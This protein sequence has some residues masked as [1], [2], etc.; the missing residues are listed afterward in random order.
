M[1]TREPDELP[2]PMAPKQQQ[3]IDR[4][5]TLIQGTDAV[6]ATHR[7]NPPNVIGYP[8]L[9]YAAFEKWRSSSCSL[10]HRICGK[11]H[12]H[13]VAFEKKTKRAFQ[14]SVKS[15]RGILESF[16]DDFRAGDFDSPTRD[17]PEAIDSI[18]MIAER[19][20][21]VARQLRARHDNRPTLELND[22][23]DMQDLIHALLRLFFD[24]VRVEEWT[25][26]YAGGSSRVD[27]LLKPEQIVIE[28]KR[29]RPTLRA[30]E[31]GTQ[32]IDDIARYRTHP[33]CHRL[34]CFV[35]DPEGLIPNPR[36]LE[37]DLADTPSDMPVTVLIRPS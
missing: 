20:H 15:G 37:T 31:L 14:S 13:T 10:L 8:T 12:P 11:E 9:D 24:D 22:E 28:T 7:P 35:Y 18:Q 21:S 30:K 1:S 26:S 25:P 6:I 19:F 34:V 29:A 5:E 23:Y 32:L 4:L 2:N 33:D 27:F 17:D 16:L 3:I 36:G